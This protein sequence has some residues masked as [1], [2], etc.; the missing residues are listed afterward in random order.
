MAVNAINLTIV[1]QL[2]NLYEGRIFFSKI[3]LEFDGNEIYQTRTS[4]FTNSKYWCDILM[5]SS[6]LLLSRKF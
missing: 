4:A 3:D 6:I 5:E 2:V 1:L